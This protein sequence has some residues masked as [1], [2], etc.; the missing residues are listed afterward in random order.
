MRVSREGFP[1]RHAPVRRA[2]IRA[3]RT[4]N[5]ARHLGKHTSPLRARADR[6]RQSSNTPT[7]S[8]L[9]NFH[10]DKTLRTFYIGFSKQWL[11]TVK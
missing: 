9:L 6:L 8:Y 11:F 7:T 4:S 5:P 10:A 3:R 2:A 1:R